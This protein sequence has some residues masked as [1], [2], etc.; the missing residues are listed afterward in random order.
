MNEQQHGISFENLRLARLFSH[1]DE[2]GKLGPWQA[3]VLVCD[4]PTYT[5]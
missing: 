2:K 4:P 1:E 5:H 3:E